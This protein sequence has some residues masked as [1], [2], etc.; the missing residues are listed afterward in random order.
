[1]KPREGSFP[2]GITPRKDGTASPPPF[3]GDPPGTRKRNSCKAIIFRGDTVLLT[4]NLDGTGVFYLLPGGGQL[5]AE[6]LADAVVREVLEET[7]WLVRPGELLL[8]R[9]Y[10]GDNHQ[11][12]G[13]DRGVHQTELMFGAEIVRHMEGAPAVPDPWQTG[14]EWVGMD[15]MEEIRIYPSA[16]ASI[17]PLLRRGAYSGPTYIGDVN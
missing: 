11:F 15:R 3:E 8:V 12:A 4:A 6:T 13:E 7:G 2:D 1:V 16:L 10:I 9:D 17:L 14:V 5:H